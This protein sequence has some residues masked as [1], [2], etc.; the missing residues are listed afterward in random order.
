MT[1]FFFLHLFLFSYC[2]S[3]GYMWKCTYTNRR[4]SL[5]LHHHHSIIFLSF[6]IKIF[7][8]SHGWRKKGKKYSAL[9]FVKK[10]GQ[11]RNSNKCEKKKILFLCRA[12]IDES[13]VNKLLSNVA[14]K[15]DA[16]R[17]MIKRREKSKF[18]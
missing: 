1:F 10:K 11:G 6:T 8:I 12:H 5:P 4:P 15:S 2:I 9:W 7:P 3:W 13:T 17:D 14:C 16:T 18:H